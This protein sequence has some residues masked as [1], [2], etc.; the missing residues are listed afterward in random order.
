MSF[1]YKYKFTSPESIF[2]LVKEE[3]KS[4]F[5]TG[6]V[7]DTLFPTWTDKCLKKLGKSSY[8]INQVILLI[9]NFEYKLPDDFYAVREAWACT[10]EETTYQL[11]S[12][13]YTE[14]KQESTRIDDPDLYCDTCNECE[15]P[16]VITAVYKTTQT[17]AFQWRKQYLLTP[18][19]MYPSCP[20]D[21]Y[22]ANYN[23][24]SEDTYD[25]RGNKF[26]T[27]FRCGKVYMQY[28]SNQ[29]DGENQ[30]VPEDYRIMEFIEL[31][32]KEKIFEQLKNQSTDETFNQMEKKWL[33]YRQMAGEA[34]IL[35]NIENTKEDVYRK[36][37]ALRRQRNK[38]RKYRIY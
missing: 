27:N 2:A 36:Q 16:D 4:Y 23:S 32:L 26:V 33:D 12:A 11:P 19:N 17:V 31:F 15:F 30:L 10:D 1:Y 29:F 7:D 5:D 14:I 24:V 20:N 21:L 34:Y 9:D 22:C 13:M 28:Y 25:I 18:G 8:P 6:A 38:F 37:R 35:A 3:L